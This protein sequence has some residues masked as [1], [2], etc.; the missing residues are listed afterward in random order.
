MKVDNT[1]LFLLFITILPLTTIY[2]Q[3]NLNTRIIHGHKNFEIEVEI[4]NRE[5]LRPVDDVLLNVF[6]LPDYQHVVS[7]TT[8]E[9]KASFF[10]DPQTEYVIE[11]CKRLYLG[12]VLKFGSCYIEDNIF[13]ISGMQKFDFKSGGGYGKPNA[14][15]KTRIAIDSIAI[16]KTF[17]LDNVYYDL[18]RWYLR[19][20]SKKELNKLF[21]ILNDFPSMKVELGSHTDSRGDSDSN[22]ELSRKRAE[23]CYNYLVKKGIDQIRIIPYG[24]GES[25]TT[26]G[27]DDG[28]ICFEHQHQKNRRTEFEI[29]SFEGEECVISTESKYKPEN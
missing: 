24:Y 23:S 13:C 6:M 15:L 19:N 17:K 27:C 9:G 22:Q 1:H 12:G 25:E 5:T 3:N 10:L 18:G 26:N 4:V 20:E 14:L 21:R 8:R 2:S 29:L 11:T 16:G 7:T 28:V